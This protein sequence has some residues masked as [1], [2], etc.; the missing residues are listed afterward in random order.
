M[1][2]NKTYVPPYTVRY[3]KQKLLRAREDL[4]H[5]ALVD[6][7]TG[8]EVEAHFDAGLGRDIGG[9][10]HLSIAEKMEGVRGAVPRQLLLDVVELNR[11]S[12]EHWKSLRPDENTMALVGKEQEVIHESDGEGLHG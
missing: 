11:P 9:H 10:Y 2:L 8:L 1:E 7:E 4:G 5:W 12:H 3:I 6:T